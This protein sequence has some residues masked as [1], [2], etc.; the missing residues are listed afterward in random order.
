MGSTCTGFLIRQLAW[1]G[2]SLVTWTCAKC[3]APD[4]DRWPGYPGL[5]RAP[6]WQHMTPTLE[7]TWHSAHN[8]LCWQGHK[9]EMYTHQWLPEIPKVTGTGLGAVQRA[10]VKHSLSYQYAHFSYHD[11]NPTQVRR[12]QIR[13][14]GVLFIKQ[15]K[16]S[17]RYIDQWL[18]PW[19]KQK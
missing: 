12:S 14:L 8:S 6:W 1:W 5:V 13:I 11:L 19:W 18:C 17:I 7:L 15:E 2:M 16:S 3:Q 4:P 10:H 9:N